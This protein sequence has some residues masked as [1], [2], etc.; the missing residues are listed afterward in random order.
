MKVMR[1][2]ASDRM[3]RAQRCLALVA[4]VAVFVF[5]LALGRGTLDPGQQGH[6]GATILPVKA[7]VDGEERIDFSA[8]ILP[9]LSDN[10]FACHGVDAKT[11]AAD[12]RLDVR[13]SAVDET[14][15]I[16]PGDAATSL[17][18]ERIL[19]DDKK[20]VMPP[21]KT[22]KTLEPEEIELIKRWI[23]Q[24]A[25]YAP[26][27][28]F[29]K[30][31]Q[32]PLPEV[33]LASW[34]IN[35][36]DRFV[37]AGLEGEGMKPAIEA[38]RRALIRRV[39]LDLTGLP[40]TVEEVDAFLADQSPQAYEKVVDRLLA[41]PRYGEHMTRYWL[42]AVR[43]GDTHG[44][45]LD[46][47]REMFPYRDWV[48]RAFN[49]NMPYD[50]F[51]KDQIAGDLAK[52]A[53]LD[54]LVAS[55]YNRAHVT[56][57]E[58]GSIAEEVYV[59][60]V[61]DR[62]DTTGTIWLGLTLSC[63]K[64]HDHKYDPITQEEYFQ[65][66]AF[67][68]SFD[69]NPM[70]GN[71]ARH[72]PV[73]RVP[74]EQDK[75]KLAELDKRL[76][77][78]NQQVAQY[79]GKAEPAFRAWLK[80]QEQQIATGEL[81]PKEI[82]A[83]ALVL[84]SPLDETEGNL[85]T[86]RANPDAAGVVKGTARWVEGHT[87]RGFSF[88]GGDR[89]EFSKDLANVE[90]DQAFSYGAWIKTP[91][92]VTGAPIAK[93]ED[94]AEHRGWDIY[95]QQRK[96]AMHLIHKWPYNAL[97]VTT[98]A[99]VLK[100]NQ[101]HHVFITY[102]GSK[103]ATGVKIY[104]DG[105]AQPFSASHDTLNGTTKTGVPLTLG[106]RT[107]GSPFNG[108]SVDDVRVYNRLLSPDEVAVLASG[109]TLTPLLAVAS[110]Q[111]TAEQDKTLRDYYL[112]SVDEQYPKLTGERNTKQQERDKVYNAAP[113]TLVFKEMSK[114]KP[115]YLLERGAYDAKGKQ[116]QRGVPDFLPQMDDGL[117][118]DR[119]GF[120]KWL[121]DPEHPLTARVTVNRFWQQLFGV[122]L[123][124]SSEDFG[125]Q[126][127][128]PSHPEL[129]DWLAVQFI[130]DGWDI[131]QTMKR[132]VMSA[133][134]RQTAAV[135]PDL[136]KQ[137]PE[138]RLLARGPR[139]RLDAEVL[140]DQVLA[141]SGLMNGE[142]GGA[143]VKPPQPGGIWKA[144]GYESSNTANFRADTGDK[145]YRRSMYVFWKRTAPAPFLT[146]FDAPNR[147][148]CTVRRERTNTAMQALI[149]LNE[150][151][152]VESARRLA[153]R[154]MREAGA[155]V[156]EKI[157]WMMLRTVI[158]KPTD[159]ELSILTAGYKEQLAVYQA[160]PAAAKQLIATGTSQPDAALDPAQLAAWTMTA[161]TLI[162]LDE[163]INKP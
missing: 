142:I 106:R 124:K 71:N 8:Q 136:Y 12:L 99:D 140:R 84:H 18:V 159:K 148:A 37:L 65:F 144:V 45:H 3:I 48:I 154:A 141:V 86:N 151:Q 29:V 25:E 64:C 13:E 6:H 153:E 92:N 62:V 149:V 152:Y 32:A 19:T 30:P 100:P 15:A 43:Y 122:G 91:G 112:R 33:K 55:G 20:L 97:K 11:R 60:N 83:E 104:I 24:G 81:K 79:P 70:D 46:N 7:E 72:A 128:Q 156:E 160:D 129:L 113:T 95:I 67:F 89:I 120:A 94:N 103:K 34:P 47:Y 162:N 145:V 21:P 88:A 49:I 4:V 69:G 22:N 78:L 73:V 1:T 155:S 75:L 44:L 53:T 111:R 163:F 132:L 80:Q 41:S 108:G 137:D 5:V 123:V 138:N 52:D 26:H 35:E 77:E 146:G 87:N 109:D 114:P 161:S 135:S 58:G 157:T 90:Q 131:K 50:R 36:V 74:S 102:D 126:G 107:P 127:T 27:W 17:L 31:E 150:P 28:A 147:E 93:M 82:S 66:F 118:M 51:T 42:D 10:C 117:S 130:K 101:W 96:V 125:V 110:D 54:Q 39:T 158:R 57:N 9:I 63:A 116:V 115:A 23:D 134:Y 16:E 40:P 38:D 139:L 68:N 59:R 133:T 2:S 76:A 143:S 121:L 105:K 119:M 14:F 98:N 61:V 56:T 85:A